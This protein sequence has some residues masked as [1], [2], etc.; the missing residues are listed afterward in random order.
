MVC[1]VVVVVWLR[2]LGDQVG[3]PVTRDP[4]TL[5]SSVARPFAPD[6]H[7]DHKSI[8]SAKLRLPNFD[9]DLLLSELDGRRVVVPGLVFPFYPSYFPSAAVALSLATAIR[10][11]ANRPIHYLDTPW[12]TLPTTHAPSLSI[13]TAAAP[14]PP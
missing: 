4:G 2:G 8:Q 3:G 7:L 12:N 5:R 1:Q 11:R 14:P 9:Y 10:L 6:A 13:I